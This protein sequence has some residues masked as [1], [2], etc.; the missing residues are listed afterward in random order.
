MLSW[1]YPISRRNPASSAKNINKSSTEVYVRICGDISIQLDVI[2]VFFVAGHHIIV[3]SRG[4][5]SGV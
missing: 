5:W 2:I 4:Q 3:V 1:W